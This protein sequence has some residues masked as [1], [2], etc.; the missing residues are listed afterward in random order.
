MTVVGTREPMLDGL[1][2]VTGR[3]RYAAD[4][5]IDGVA[6]AVLL[7][8]PH[9]H[10]RVL[11]LDPAAALAAP[12]VLGVFWHGNMP[13]HRYNS[14]I[15]FEGQEADADETMF[16]ATVR[17]I[18]DRV[19]VV[20]AESRPQAEAALDLLEVAY[21]SL[22]PC[23][24]PEAADRMR[25]PLFDA[26]GAPSFLNPVAERHFA[27]GDVAAGFAA[28]AHVTET[29]VR[30]PKTH[31]CAIETHV[32]VALPEAG[33]RICVMAPCQ[34]V[35]A[36]Q[37]VVARALGMAA[38]DV[39]VIKTPI[40]GSFGGKAEPVLEPIAAELARR[41]GRP[42]RLA[43][44]RQQTFTSTRMR[45][46]TATRIRS[47]LAADGRIL[48]RETETLIDIGAYVTGGNYLP[49]SMLQRHVRLYAIPA[50]SYAGRA[51]YTNTPPTGAFRGYGSPQINAAGEI[52]LDIAARRAGLDPVA[53]RLRNAV[54]PDAIEPYTGLSVG[55]A[56]LADCLRDGA[57][58]F[59]WAERNGRPRDT[60]RLRR[61][62][63][64]AAA[65]HVN[66]C[67]P[68]SDEQT[69]MTMS[70]GPDGRITMVSA[71]HDLGCGSNTTLAQIAAEVLGLAP[72]DLRIVEA[73]TDL[74]GYDL[75]TRASRMTYVQG[76]AT[77]RTALALADR[78]LSAAGRLGNVA[79]EDLAL[80]GGGIGNRRTGRTT[81]L[82][83]LAA[84]LLHAGLELPAA[85]E[86]HV[87]T[88]NPS[89]HAAHFAEVEVDSL[90]GLVRV[91]DYLAV[92]DIGRAINPMLVEGQIHGGVQIGIGYA[93]FEDVANDP[94]T[95]RM[96][97]RSFARYILANSLE[98]PPVTV[99]LVEAGE[100]SGPF[101]AKA[102][103]EIATIPVAAAVV[104]AVNAALG[105]EL[106]D[107]PL[108]PARVL[109]ALQG[110]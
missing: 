99:R 27:Q 15:W 31:H 105:T 29:T 58:A 107:L 85:T 70:L 23:L 56:R 95:G 6:H 40:G 72:A 3:L 10:A 47:A 78:I 76:E 88:A 43:A 90:T 51:V 44:D 101:G 1:A 24:T 53:L 86:T 17:H 19:A 12:G 103:G 100:A 4:L 108:I 28:A 26:A 33:G 110:A 77:R 46:A 22:E 25:G 48:A 62:V 54:A 59:G 18:G 81:S 11:S 97:G 93:L 98:M 63:G 16:P 13:A 60:G 5:Q 57:A 61:G 38:A 42:V 30:T 2:K 35:H 39:H 75:G 73:D 80:V 91:T 65:A 87:A 32:A 7:T 79:P 50:E 49:G 21:D 94:F 55:N 68:G 96:G 83:T 71:L 52:H 82:A 9:P 64:M 106:T 66:G 89:S 74:C 92:H 34:S 84:D 69:T 109:D 104:N 14:S 36:T 102:V 45:S 8:S 37:V 67:F 20:V 41:L